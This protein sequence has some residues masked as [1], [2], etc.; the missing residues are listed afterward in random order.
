MSLEPA[1]GAATGFV[2]LGELLAPIVVGGIALVV[3]ASI[4]IVHGERSRG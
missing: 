4:G 1:F 2:V 3:M